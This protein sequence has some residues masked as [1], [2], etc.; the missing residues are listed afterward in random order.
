MDNNNKLEIKC[1]KH[2]RV[3][4][5]ELEIEKRKGVRLVECPHCEKIHTIEFD[6]NE[7]IDLYRD[8]YRD[9]RADT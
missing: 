4:H 5:I 2:D 3:F 6:K 7:N 8:L 9:K 1:K